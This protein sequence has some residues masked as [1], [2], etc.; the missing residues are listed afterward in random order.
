MLQAVQIQQ[1]KSDRQSFIITSV[2]LALLL[3]TLLFIKLHNTIIDDA[4][5]GV[6]IDF[7]DNEDGLGDDN[8]REAGGNNTSTPSPSTAPS[9]PIPPSPPTPT[10]VKTVTI[11][12]KST[13][14][15]TITAEDA[16]AVAIAKMQK[17][18]QVRQQKAQEE[19]KRIADMVRKAEQERLAR[20]AEEKKIRDQMAGVFSKGKTGSGTGTGNATGGGDGNGQG[21]TKPGGN[22]G[23]Q[24]GTPGGDPNGTGTGTKGNGPGSGNGMSYDL[25]GRT[26]RQKPLV[27]DNSQ[28]TGR[29]V[30]AIKVDKNGNVVY[31]QYQQKGSNT[32]DP[33][34]IQ[35]AE[36]GALK[37]KF[38]SDLGADEEQFGTIT[39]NFSVQ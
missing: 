19:Q 38:S 36:Q 31:A 26:W 2:V 8:L 34:L 27:F 18:E 24:W 3:L 23:A 21:N 29:V 20:E 15:N 9:T 22:Q 16:Q 33:Y 7:G 1:Q 14:T 12:V 28:K 30:V 4:I 37:A 10:P 39:F 35:L 6:M 13:P 11:P 5:S 25:K 17:E 32:T